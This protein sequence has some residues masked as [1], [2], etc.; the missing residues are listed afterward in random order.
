VASWSAVTTT[1]QQLLAARCP[2][3]VGVDRFEILE[4]ELVI[5]ASAPG[6]G[7]DSGGVSGTDEGSTSRYRLT[8]RYRLLGGADAVA[9]FSE[10]VEFF[11]PASLES[12]GGHAADGDSGDDDEALLAGLARLV[13][14]AA[15]TSYYKVAAPT[16]IAVMLGPITA[17]EAMFV[18]ELYDHGMR[19]FA[20][21]NDLPVPLDQRWE[22]EIDASR[23]PTR[24]TPDERPTSASDG[25]AAAGALV[26][27]GGGKDS[28]LVLSVLGDRAVAFTINAT[29]APRRV[30]AAAGLTLHTAARRLDPA[31]RDWNERGALNG[32]IP[33][34]AV[35][36][37][38]SALAARAHGCTDVVLGNERSASEPTR[39]VGG[40]AV[41]HQW[42]KSLIAE[43]LT[44]GA[45]DAVSGGRLRTFSILRPFTEVAIASGL[46]TDEAQLG[47]F[48]SCNEAFTIW[49]PTAQRAEGTWCLN[50]PKCRFTTLMM[51]P[52]L[53]P[54]RFEEIFGGRPLHDPDQAEG[55]RELWDEVSKPYECVGEM[56]ESAAAMAEL[57]GRDAWADAAVVR[58]TGESATAY[59][60]DHHSS[61]AALMVPSA[62]H[63][64]PEPYLGWMLERLA[65]EPTQR[66]AG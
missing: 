7:N 9:D 55:Y 6:A 12:L 35:V 11:A 40:Q 1:P 27:V 62:D 23:A 64:V 66:S 37:A 43:D 30:A 31:L 28:A 15:G 59:A 32:H 22:L 17:A 56:V 13:A 51:A 46:V 25:L 16:T 48:L 47:A 49:R 50:C 58:L 45:L 44:Q 38:I 3:L 65:P 2:D 26:P 5:E 54:E 33:V 29:E 21:R 39:W 20:A 41:N 36:T 18:R 42:A 10:V 52:H 19:E 60:G 24:V 63:R 53:S 8:L 34:T 57:A 4:P 61:L 14:L